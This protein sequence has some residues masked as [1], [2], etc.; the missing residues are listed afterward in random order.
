MQKD[1]TSYV[2][3]EANVDVA[4]VN[5]MKVM[6]A[7]FANA[8]RMNAQKV[9]LDLLSIFIYDIFKRSWRSQSAYSFDFFLFLFPNTL[10]KLIFSQ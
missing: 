9:K 5:A 6:L 8:P 1:P 7:N 3:E 10:A 4:N 2:T